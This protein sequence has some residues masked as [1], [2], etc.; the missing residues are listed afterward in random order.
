[1]KCTLDEWDIFLNKN[2]NMDFNRYVTVNLT[3]SL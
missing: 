1:M 2:E 3:Y